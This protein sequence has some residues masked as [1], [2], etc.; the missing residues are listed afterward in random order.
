MLAEKDDKLNQVTSQL[1]RERD[2]LNEKM[3]EIQ[4]LQNKVEEQ[5][6]Q[7]DRLIKE[8]ELIDATQAKDEDAKKDIGRKGR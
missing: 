6:A 2:G 1:E 5:K 7:L 8:K 3:A 4:Q